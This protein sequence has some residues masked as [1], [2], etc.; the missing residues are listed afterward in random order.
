MNK[1]I[2]A[3]TVL[4]LLFILFFIYAYATFW[5]T[6]VS[7]NFAL[8]YQQLFEPFFYFFVL[9]GGYLILFK[10]IYSTSK[11]KVRFN[12]ANLLLP[13]ILLLVILGVGA[14]IHTSAQM[15]EDAFGH[16]NGFIYDLAFFLDE[17]P[18]HLLVSVPGF[19]LIYFLALVEL[20]R[21]KV[22]LNSLKKT[23]VIANS[24]IHGLFYV[25]GGYEGGSQY[26]ILWPLLLI[27]MIKLL[28]RRKQFN[29]DL[30]NYPYTLFFL[31]S[32]LICLLLTPIFGLIFGFNIQPETDLG[33][34]I[35]F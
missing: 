28:H 12:E 4:T 33:W 16:S 17:Y 27:L 35:Y 1:T 9:S 11:D 23:L 29:I 22:Q 21:K 8:T 26:I 31:L 32:I 14:G 13:S 30:W 18:G 19:I 6:L 20:N 10:T 7:P 24:I 2:K 15:I 3:I 5:Q 25:I 34:Q